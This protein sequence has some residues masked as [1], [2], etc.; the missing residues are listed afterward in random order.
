MP[1]IDRTQ[2]INYYDTTWLD[3]RIAWMNSENLAMHHGYWDQTTRGHG[4]SLLNMN[5]ELAAMVRIEP[6][7]RVLDAGCGVGG[8][9]IWLAENFEV[10][11][12]GISLS[13]D[14]IRRARESAH[15]R[16]VDDRV[17]FQVADF[18]DSGLDPSSFDV[19]WALESCCH[20][21]DKRAFAAEAFRLL[22]PGGQ[23]A[24]GDGF[25]LSRTLSENDEDLLRSLLASWAVNDICTV[26]EFI[27]LTQQT[28]FSDARA[29]DISPNVYPSVQRLSW[30]AT[31]YQPIG[32]LLHKLAVRPRATYSNVV[33]AKLTGKSF[34]RHLACY[35]LVA[36][37]KEDSSG[38]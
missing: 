15:S 13:A 17:T 10:N 21:A 16:N 8:S 18:V 3:Y 23:L 12:V 24:V 7:M 6:G 1:T 38:N 35:A 36:A 20:A 30:M 5:R 9:S 29:R 4:D 19:V 31:V 28:G 25:R 37:R 14:Q 22:R 34:R 26:S 33:A 32:W 2:I 27:D 11:V